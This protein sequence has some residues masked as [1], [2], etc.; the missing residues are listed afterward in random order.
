MNYMTVDQVA[1]VLGYERETIRKKVKELFPDIVKAGVKTFLNEDE[2]GILKSSLV[3]RT[4]ALKSGVDSVS[5]KKDM[6]EKAH[7]VMAWMASEVESLRAELAQAQPAIESHAALM[8]TDRTMSITDA[9]K[10]FGLHPKTE[11]FP[12]LRE[13][14]YLTR[15]D[16]PTEAAISAGYLALKETACID[17]IA[18]PQAVIEARMLETWRTRVVP[19]IAKWIKEGAA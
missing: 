8:R 11:V 9:A 4:L 7:E 13:H 2:V 16:I 3:P 6:M 1:D 14:G 17:G 12:Y 5:T 18:R 15:K 10:H 19:Q